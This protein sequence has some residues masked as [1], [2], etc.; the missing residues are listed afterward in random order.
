METVIVDIIRN[1]LILIIFNEKSKTKNNSLFS[2]FPPFWYGFSSHSVVVIR[3]SL[4]FHVK[5]SVVLLGNSLPLYGSALSG[6]LY[7]A[8]SS[9]ISGWKL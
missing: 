6:T 4:G 1:F 2:S 3:K 5:V 9:C 8:N 7:L